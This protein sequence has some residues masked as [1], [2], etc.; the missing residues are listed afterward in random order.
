MNF[1]NKTIWITGAAS[2]IGKAVAEQ[3]SQ[4]KT[5]LI[6]SDIYENGLK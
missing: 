3:L 1:A 5:T 4:E 6:L 2:G